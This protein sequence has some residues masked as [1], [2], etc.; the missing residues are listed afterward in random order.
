MFAAVVVPLNDAVFVVALVLIFTVYPLN[1]VDATPS[2]L[3]VIVTLLFGSAPVTDDSNVVAAFIVCDAPEAVT[4]VPFFLS[5]A[6]VYP[7]FA[8]ALAHTEVPFNTAVF[9]LRGVPLLPSAI[10]F[11]VDPSP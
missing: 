1:A 7:L 8:V 5:V 9:A 6:P 10:V 11:N 3:S 2:F 4:V